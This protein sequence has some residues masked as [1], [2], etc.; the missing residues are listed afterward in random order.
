M[1]FYLLCPKPAPLILQI[2]YIYKYLHLSDTILGVSNMRIRSV[3]HK[4]KSSFS[5]ISTA[6]TTIYF[7]R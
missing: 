3:F 4:Q 2:P 5:S 7:P 6:D 1:S